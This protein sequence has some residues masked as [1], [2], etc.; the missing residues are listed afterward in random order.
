MV[1][2][3]VCYANQITGCCI[4]ETSELLQKKNRIFGNVIEKR[5]HEHQMK[6]ELNALCYRPWVI[7]WLGLFRNIRTLCLQRIS[8][9]LWE[10]VPIT[11]KPSTFLQAEQV[12]LTILQHY[13]LLRID[14]NDRAKRDWAV[15]M[16]MLW[17]HLKCAI[18]RTATAFTNGKTV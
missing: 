8:I 12:C 1:F 5:S 6:F 13:R 9:F 3:L 4:P 11:I 10:I 15:T 2:F 7:Y 14:N 16:V 18:F 17:N